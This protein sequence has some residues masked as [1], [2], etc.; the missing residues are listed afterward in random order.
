[1]KRVFYDEIVKVVMEKC[2]EM[3]IYMDEK[4][5][6]LLD[7]AVEEEDSN[8]AKEILKDLLLNQE[9]AKEELIPLCQDTGMIIAFVELGQSVIIEGGSLSDAI[10]EGVEKGYQ[11][12]HLR[13]S[14]VGCPLR[15][16]NTNSNTPAIIYYDVVEGETLKIILAAKGFGS[17]N[18]SSVKM[19]KP[20]EGV[21]GVKEFVLETI[22]KAGG[23]CC[24]PIIVGVGIGGSFDK[25]A[26]LAKKALLRDLMERN[27]DPY[28]AELEGELLEAVN[29]L[30]IGPQGFG[31]KTTAL[32]LQIETYPTHIAGLPV[33][34]NIN[35]HASRHKDILF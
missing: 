6:I 11:D 35:C 34:V 27:K 15:R 32:A 13:K 12:G 19:L 8:L 1:M 7:K 10:N 22:Q 24:P 20:S 28:L 30:G 14:V 29:Q 2:I 26:L 3:N 18:M 17:E 31:G 21:E 23:N 33:A 16:K 9:V 4:L 25:A 5:K